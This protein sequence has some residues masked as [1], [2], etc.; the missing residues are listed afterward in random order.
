MCCC[1]YK[2]AVLARLTPALRSLLYDYTQELAKQ[3]VVQTN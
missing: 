1:F 3:D 2:L